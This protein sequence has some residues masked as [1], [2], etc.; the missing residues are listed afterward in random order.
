MINNSFVLFDFKDKFI[1]LN[2]KL[3]RKI[4][5]YYNFYFLILKFMKRASEIQVNHKK[6]NYIRKMS[7]S[8]F[9][10]PS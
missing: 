2:F 1:Q 9:F 7:R 5:Q 3:F 10:K 6:S 4:K 8:A